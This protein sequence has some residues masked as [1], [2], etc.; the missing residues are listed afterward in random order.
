MNPKRAVVRSRMRVTVCLLPWLVMVATVAGN[1]QAQDLQFRS[2]PEVLPS[3]RVKLA[4]GSGEVNVALW[5]SVAIAQSASGEAC[6]ATLVGPRVLLTAAHCVD[7]GDPQ[8]PARTLGGTVK[9]GGSEIPLIGCAMHPAYAK[10]P[11]VS[12][13]LVR[14]SEDYALCE[15]AAPVTTVTQE[16]IDT[17]P[18]IASGAAILMMGFGCT[19]I[20]VIGGQF[21]TSGADDSLR[22]GD[23]DID[24]VDVRD[25]TN[26]TGVYVRTRATDREPILCPGDS[27]G[28]AFRGASVSKQDGPK[29]R[30]VA[31]NS[32]VIA[33]EGKGR[34]V[35]LS[36]AASVISPS[37]REFQQAWT[38][39]SA[40]TRAVCGLDLSAGKGGCRL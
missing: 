4:N 35:F 32:Q 1:A 36:F 15:L 8:Q 13:D 10:A 14:S 40:S 34:Y 23:A 2:L 11:F 21:V 5:S 38:K 12:H 7:A 17:E 27:G 24:A 39:Q 37:F 6:T 31:V 33:V 3:G 28:P 25:E 19:N 16:T 9:F 26:A 22:L 30:L 18:K 29:R 20:R